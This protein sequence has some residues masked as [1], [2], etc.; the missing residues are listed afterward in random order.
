LRAATLGAEEEA[1]RLF[2]VIPDPDDLRQRAHAAR[3]AAKQA[4]GYALNTTLQAEYKTQAAHQL[5]EEAD[6]L[7]NDLAAVEAQIGSSLDGP[8]TYA[9]P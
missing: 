3:W 8:Q 7:E 4:E 6:Q 1:L 5:T 9:T 2:P